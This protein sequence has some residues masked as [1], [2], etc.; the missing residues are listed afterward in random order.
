MNPALFVL[1]QVDF[2][3]IGALPFFFFRR[4]GRLNFA[5]FVTSL[6][7]LLV[8]LALI[9]G[10]AGLLEPAPTL[11]ALRLALES[12]AT[13]FGAGSLAL[14]ILTV[15]AHRVSPA[16][17]HQRQELDV[18]AE[19][20][21]WGPYAWIRHPFYTSYL[22]AFVGALLAF[23]GPSTACTLA[24]AW[25]VLRVTAKREEDRLAAGRFGMRYRRYRARTG[26]FLPRIG[27]RHG[28]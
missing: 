24:Y 20:V 4:D 13:L 28:R 10:A 1:L 2:A 25:V 22:L 6:P 21:T 7:F 12:L 16:L 11:P 14:L 23:P 9:A 17:W 8:F 15:A 27:T 18:P 19:I 26:R 3:I 5:W